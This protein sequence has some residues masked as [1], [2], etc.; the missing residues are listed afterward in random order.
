V[1]PLDRVL[2]VAPASAAALGSPFGGGDCFSGSGGAAGG[3]GRV[4]VGAETLRTHVEQLGIGSE[5]RQ[6]A[7]LA[8][9]QREQAPPPAAH[10]PA[11][12][13]W[14]SEAT[15][16]WCSILIGVWTARP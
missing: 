16:S 15:G 8:Y 13:I 4:A 7:Q 11:S 3:A 5:S 10:A 9:V 12:G 1:Q 14:S 2:G 6:Q